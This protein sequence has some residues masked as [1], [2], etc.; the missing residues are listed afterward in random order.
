MFVFAGFLTVFVVCYASVFEFAVSLI[1]LVQL[2]LVTM[3]SV[4]ITF[5]DS[6]AEVCLGFVY[7]LVLCVLG[8]IVIV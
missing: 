7:C 1:D 3:F 6:V 8:L 4:V 2:L 5:V